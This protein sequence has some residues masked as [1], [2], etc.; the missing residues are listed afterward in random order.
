MQINSLDYW[1]ERFEK[2][3]DSKGGRN[4]TSYFTNL[5]LENLPHEFLDFLRK[6]KDFSILDWGCAE[7]DGVNLLS[8]RLP[9]VTLQGL[10]YSATAIEKAKSNYPQYDFYKGSLL[11]YNLKYN[12]IFTSNTLEH[13]E[14]PYKWIDQI[15][16]HTKDFLIIMVPFM[17]Q[18]RIEEHFFTFEHESFPIENNG[19]IIVYFKIIESDPEYWP[20][21]QILIVYGNSK[22]KLLKEINLKQ[23]DSSSID[24]SE[25]ATLLIRKLKDEIKH[26]DAI[27]GAFSKEKETY[28]AW[29]EASKQE[30]SKRDESVIALK[31]EIQ[32]YKAENSSLLDWVNKSKE[33]ILKRDE[34]V[35]YYKNKLESLQQ[36]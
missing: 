4:Q 13:F 28:L 12:I 32:N 22:S 3:W 5:A 33:E 6:Q 11:D 15:I 8:H 30:V 19:F 7:G 16:E 24:S 25:S 29:L 1:N 2:D 14:N 10:D 27:I 18:D 9:E 17:E 34:T 31:S 35:Y 20:G 36:E 21:K 23:I 26:R